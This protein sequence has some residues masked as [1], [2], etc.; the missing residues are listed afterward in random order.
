MKQAV[1][2]QGKAEHY[3]SKA[4]AAE[5]NTAISSDDPEALEK[6]KAKLQRLQDYQEHMKNINAWH[7]KYLKSPDALNDSGLSD[8]W[9]EQ[10]KNF[11][12]RYSFDKLYYPKY[13]LT[14]N[15]GNMATIRKRI[16]HLERLNA[17]QDKTVT[18]GNIKIVENASENRIQIFFPF[19]PTEAVR[20]ELKHGGFRWTPS[21]GA[22]QAYYSDWAIREANR[23]VNSI[24]K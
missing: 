20:S 7:R 9:K 15:N 10:I 22:W 8:E 3:D 19:K 24:S 4:Q 21:I 17:R 1:E 18:V 5:D 23:I 16:E 14:N 2:L 6:L 13:K 12:P 11:V